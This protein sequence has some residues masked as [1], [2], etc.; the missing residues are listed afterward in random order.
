M[1]I[2]IADV[3]ETKDFSDYPERNE[4]ILDDRPA[5]FDREAFSNNQ[6]KRVRPG[7]PKYDD[8]LTLE[9]VMKILDKPSD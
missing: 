2:D 8:A 4:F 1:M 6:I 9:E 7:N 5:K 3:P